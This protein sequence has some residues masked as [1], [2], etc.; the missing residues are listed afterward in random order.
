MYNMGNLRKRFGLRNVLACRLLDMTVVVGINYLDE[1]LVIADTRVSYSNGTYD[2]SLGVKKLLILGNVD[3]VAVVGF[4]GPIEVGKQVFKYLIQHKHP[5]RRRF[6]IE[7]FKDDLARWIQEAASA[8]PIEKLKGSSFMLAALEPSR[9]LPMKRRGQIVPSPFIESHLYTYRYTESGRLQVERHRNFAVIGSGKEL[10]STIVDKAK[11]L[12]NF[13]R[14]MPNFRLTRAI[15]VNE[16][17]SSLFK[18][19]GSK[20]VGGP[21]QVVRIAPPPKPSQLIYQWLDIDDADVVVNNIGDT[22]IMENQ[23]TGERYEL[24]SIWDCNW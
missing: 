20:T 12:I 18:D 17:I 3:K 7:T 4:S 24:I 5:Q 2:Q 9:R 1:I 11:A 13:G 19:K 15:V 6:V 10:E 16:V 23:K 14:K 21:Y 22:T 8:L